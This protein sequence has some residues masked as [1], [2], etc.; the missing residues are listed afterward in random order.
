M[1]V[2]P[3]HCIFCG[4]ER[5]TKEHLWPAWMRNVLGPSISSSHSYATG[6]PLRLRKITDRTG[7]IQS[8]KLRIVCAHCNNGWMSRLQ[9]NV[10]D[11]LVPLIRGQH[12]LLNDADHHRISAW[13][14]MFTMVLEFLDPHTLATTQQ[15]RKEFSIVPAPNNE[16]MIWLGQSNDWPRWDFYHYGWLHGEQ[17]DDGK[18]LATTPLSA[19]TAPTCN[20]QTTTIRVGQLLVHTYSTRTPAV[21]VDPIMFALTHGL[22]LLWPLPP[23]PGFNSNPLRRLT[24][25]QV[26]AVA[27]ELMGRIAPS[28]PK[29]YGPHE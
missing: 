25:D 16:W 12:I 14:M 27:W 17:A 15:E 24:K 8:R 7:S 2:R 13:A 19:R 18:F 11:I 4:G 20:S 21:H 26:T 28:Y 3:E 23:D 9:S 6:G 5:L 29:P 10:K 1:P 22:H